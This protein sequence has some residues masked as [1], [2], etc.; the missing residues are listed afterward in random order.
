MH[1][2]VDSKY[3]CSYSSST[4]QKEKL[5]AGNLPDQHKRNNIWCISWPQ[6]DLR[7]SFRKTKKRKKRSTFKF[8]YLHLNLLICTT[9]YYWSN[10]AGDSVRQFVLF[11]LEQFK[12]RLSK[13]ITATTLVTQS[14][15][16]CLVGKLKVWQHCCNSTKIIMAR[17]SPPDQHR[18]ER[19]TSGASPE[20]S[21]TW[22]ELEDNP[23]KQ[24][25]D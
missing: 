5:I 23:R 10:H 9:S 2:W 3:K 6:H 19:I 17:N 24:D 12:T 20:H 18:R 11:T 1:G 16:L 15:Q 8:R 13:E 21:M 22:T 4:V 25:F 7:W 14:N